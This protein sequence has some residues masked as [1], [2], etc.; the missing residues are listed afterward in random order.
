MNP[1]ETLPLSSVAG[2][3]DGTEDD[4]TTPVFQFSEED[5]AILRAALPEPALQREADCLAWW[6]ALPRLLAEGEQ[7]SFV[8]ID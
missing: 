1:T 2:T 6:R 8:L 7:D 4:S 3:A 5:L